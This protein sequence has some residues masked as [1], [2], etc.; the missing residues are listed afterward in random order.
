MRAVQNK[1]ANMMNYSYFFGKKV[2]WLRSTVNQALS[3][4]CTTFRIF[5]QQWLWWIGS[6]NI[7]TIYSLCLKSI[8]SNR[9]LNNLKPLWCTRIR[10]TPGTHDAMVTRCLPLMNS[11]SLHVSLLFILNMV[12]LRLK[13]DNF[14]WRL[15][16]WKCVCYI[17]DR[18][19]MFD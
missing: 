2:I 16:L 13:G 19:F 15:L 9:N 14:A 5:L 12:W 11:A 10:L 8:S 1:S 4:L 18:P 17:Y 6:E 3:A 7:L